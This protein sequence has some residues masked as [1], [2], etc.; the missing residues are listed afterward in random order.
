MDNLSDDTFDLIVE[1][2]QK[3]IDAVKPSDTCFTLEAMPWA[4]PFSPDSYLALIKAI[5]RK[6][7]A[8]HLDPVNMVV[9]PEIYF[10][11]GK[12]IRECFSK[13]GSFIRSCHAKDI[14]LREDIYTPHLDEVRAGLGKLDYNV[15]LLELSKLPD[16]PLMLEHLN[17]QEEYKSAAEYIRGIGRNNGII[18]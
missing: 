16:V 10:N 2:T 18:L 13:L 11:N 3:I 8:V 7:F 9:S 17:T 6:S 12:M 1:T 4:F 5:D 14:V 15:F